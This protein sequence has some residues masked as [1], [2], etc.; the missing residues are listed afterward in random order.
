MQAVNKLSS[1]VSN[2]SY[3]R[4]VPNRDDFLKLAP[5]MAVDNRLDLLA[6][7]LGFVPNSMIRE[8]R[9]FGVAT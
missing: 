1:C 3:I 8:E 9:I 4:D 5:Q 7:E 6:Q 2:K